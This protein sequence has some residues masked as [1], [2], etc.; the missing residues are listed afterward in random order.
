M[1]VREQYHRGS[2]TAANP[3]DHF[4]LFNLRRFRA[5]D[6]FRLPQKKRLLDASEYSTASRKAAR[7]S[8]PASLVAQHYVYDTSSE[9]TA[10]I[11][12]HPQVAQTLVDA[13]PHI[14]KFFG[15]GVSIALRVSC[16]QE[17]APTLSANIQTTMEVSEARAARKSFNTS[18]W[19]RQPDT[20]GYMV[21]FSLEYV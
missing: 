18:W 9:V 15:E 19:M 14:K 3:C 2:S 5:T 7:D 8:D 4:T 17:S 13:V 6:F 21:S 11:D 16:D 10:I 1:S 20:D 12:E